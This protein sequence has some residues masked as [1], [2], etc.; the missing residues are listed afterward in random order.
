M[1][2]LGETGRGRG[3]ATDTKFSFNST[4]DNTAIFK[5][6]YKP[7]QTQKQCS[8]VDTIFPVQEK[9]KVNSYTFRNMNCERN[10][11]D[12]WLRITEHLHLYFAQERILN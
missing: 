9:V 2:V 6:Y 8:K 12:L 4:Q 3:I 5:I 10:I 7:L 1:V 11:Q